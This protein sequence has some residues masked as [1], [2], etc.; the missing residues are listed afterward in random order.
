MS[1][2]RTQKPL[3]HKRLT[4][5]SRR[6]NID[7]RQSCARAAELARAGL[8]SAKDVG[9]RLSLTV[10]LPTAKCFHDVPES[11]DILTTFPREIARFE[12]RAS[13]RSDGA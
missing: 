6:T 2:V 8:R 3:L 13:V 7:H 4:V 9:T 5:M 11:I 10:A 12:T 1:T